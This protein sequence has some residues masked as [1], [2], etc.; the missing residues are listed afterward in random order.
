MSS[1]WLCRDRRCCCRQCSATDRQRKCS[2]AAGKTRICDR[3]LVVNGRMIR[4]MAVCNLLDGKKEGRAV[5][6]QCLSRAKQ[7]RGTSA[8]TSWACLGLLG[9]KLELARP[10]RFDAR[11]RKQSFPPDMSTATGRVFEFGVI[12]AVVEI[13]KHSEVKI[14]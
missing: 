8:V 1:D 14:R 2:V 11:A 7:S 4:Q 5:W 13:S 12:G 6:W 10:G 9:L 3:T